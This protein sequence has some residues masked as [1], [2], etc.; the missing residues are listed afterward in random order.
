LHI[1]RL[2]PTEVNVGEEF[3]VQLRVT[4]D[5]ALPAIS[6]R[7][8]F[9]DLVLVDPGT[10]FINV[11]GD[12]LKGVI[13]EPQAGTMKTFTYRLRCPQASTFTIAGEARTRGAEPVFAV[14]TITCK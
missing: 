8:L 13:L 9:G 4:T 3:T 14:S 6:V 7:E 10:D 12:T 1:E 11:E 5:Q 2:A